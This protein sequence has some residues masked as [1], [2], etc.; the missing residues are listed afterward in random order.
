MGADQHHVTNRQGGGQLNDL[1]FVAAFLGAQMLFD[2]IKSFNDHP[3]LGRENL[4]Y[5][6]GFGAVFAGN[7]SYVVVGFYFH[8]HGLHRFYTDYTDYRD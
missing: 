8:R 4:D 7:H 2:N 1:A 6:A 5:L 3:A